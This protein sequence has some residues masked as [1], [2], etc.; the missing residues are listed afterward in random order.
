MVAVRDS[1]GE[2]GTPEDLMAKYGLNEEAI[3]QAAHRVLSRRG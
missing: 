2:S 3:V 1:F